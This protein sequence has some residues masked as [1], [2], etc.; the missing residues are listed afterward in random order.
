MTPVRGGRPFDVYN[1]MD[2]KNEL[3]LRYCLWLIAFNILLAVVSLAT[4]VVQSRFVPP[5]AGSTFERQKPHIPDWPTHT[6][7]VPRG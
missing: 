1:V 7:D 4:V 5:Q 2:E 3:R 6:K